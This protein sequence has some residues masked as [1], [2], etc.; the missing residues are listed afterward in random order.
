MACRKACRSLYEPRY[1][2]LFR[3]LQA[4]APQGSS[5]I[6]AKLAFGHILSAGSAP[7][8]LMQDS[9]SGLPACGVCATVKGLEETANGRL[10]VTYQGWRRF[11]LLTVDHDSKPYPMAAASWLDDVTANLTQEQQAATDKLEQQVYGL[12]QQVATYMRQLEQSS[13]SAAVAAPPG[14]AAMNSSSSSSSKAQLPLLP[15]S[16][17]LFAPPPPS[18]QQSMADYLIK[19]GGSTGDKIATWQRM[20]SVYG[21]T[22]AKKKPPQDP[23]QAARDQLGKERRQE[24]FSFA[25]ASVLELGLPERLAL[26]HCTDTA[27]RLQYVAAAVQPFLADLVARVSLQQAIVRQ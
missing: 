16:V 2:A 13:G 24:L 23:Y 14:P 22:Q 19:A 10:Q 8:A 7:P 21:S 4:A 3:D 5:A 18:R 6:E 26:L 12:L 11:K 1:L 9:V 27:A 15:D 17:L 20:G 25:A